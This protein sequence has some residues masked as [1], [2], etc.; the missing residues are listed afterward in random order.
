M[1]VVWQKV[2]QLFD[3]WNKF[4]S[5]FGRSFYRYSCIACNCIERSMKNKEN[6]LT[7]PVG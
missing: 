1:T 3:T 2:F 7:L 5:E 6:V 4:Y